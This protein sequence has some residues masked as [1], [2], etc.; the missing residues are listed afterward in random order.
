MICPYD[1]LSVHLY[2][3]IGA[4]GYSMEQRPELAL[5]TDVYFIHH[6]TIQQDMYLIERLREHKKI[7]NLSIL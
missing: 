3:K 5:S 4:Y 2:S 6:K 7:E 1:D